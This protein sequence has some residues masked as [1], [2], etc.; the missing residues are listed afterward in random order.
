VK[1]PRS[2]S[3]ADIRRLIGCQLPDAIL[4]GKRSF[5]PRSRAVH[6]FTA[7]G[8]R[9]RLF[10][11]LEPMIAPPVC[12]PSA[13]TLEIVISRLR[14]L[15]PGRPL[16]LAARWPDATG[17]ASYLS[18]Y[19]SSRFGHVISSIADL[20]SFSRVLPR[21]RVLPGTSNPFPAFR[22]PNST[23]VLIRSSNRA[24]LGNCDSPR[25]ETLLDYLTRLGAVSHRSWP[26]SSFFAR[27]T[28]RE[29][30]QRNW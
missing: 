8:F 15:A 29:R 2:L 23:P 1:S 19:L 27:L 21:P 20:G 28:A 25:F 26:H 18:G 5:R 4:H 6:G 24:R 12:E 30:R 16:L 11:S 7:D 13:D 9:V 10:S 14:H 22:P 3:R 17:L